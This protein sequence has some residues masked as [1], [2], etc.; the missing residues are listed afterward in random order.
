MRY[1]SKFFR[2][3]C[4]IVSVFTVL[5]LCAANTF[6]APIDDLNDKLKELEREQQQIQSSIN[7]IKNDKSKQNEYKSQ[8]QK[9]I[10]NTES[11]ISTYMSSI[12]AVEEEL[13]A[14]DVEIKAKEEELD[15]IK[16]EFRLRMREIC[17]NGG[18]AA[19]MTISALMGASD[20][21]D[22]LTVAEYS[23]NMATYDDMIMDGLVAS[24]NDI[25]ARQKELEAKR[26]QLEGYKSTLSAKQAS[27]KSQIE[28]INSLL[29]NLG[30]QETNLN[31]AYAKLEA[32]EKKIQQQIE[33]LAREGGSTVFTGFFKWPLPG[34]RSNYKLTSPFDP[35]RVH[36]IYGRP[37][38]H[39]G[40]DYSTGGIY[41]KP[42]YAAAAGT[43]TMASYE[44][45]GYG[46]FVMINHGKYNGSTYATLYAHMVRYVVSKGA[47]VSQGQ[48]IGYVGMTGAATGPHLHLEVRINGKATSTQP[49]F[50]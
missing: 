12:T 31:D 21:S 4:G 40:D 18:N 3:L 25:K 10:K 35:S 47:T 13:N 17:M 5:S 6:A 46:Y 24:V 16:Y 7:S 48:L 32:Q 2:L 29:K 41:G 49:F 28:E 1:K 11:Q 36:P 38:P 15:R 27:L 42:I 39:N 34:S 44:D 23:E 9:Q 30:Q 26:T 37:R 20:F 22:V 33:E 8:L 50:K 45:G 19:G 14:T 43:V